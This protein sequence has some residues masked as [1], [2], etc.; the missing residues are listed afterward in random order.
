MAILSLELLFYYLLNEC[1]MAIQTFIFKLVSHFIINYLV[2]NFFE[3]FGI[4]NLK[5]SL[6]GLC[7]Y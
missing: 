1:S 6:K 5:K 4:P 3:N 7:L 2:D